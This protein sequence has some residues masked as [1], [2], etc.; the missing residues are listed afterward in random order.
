MMMMS[1]QGA[2][3]VNA[4]AAREGAGTVSAMIRS[5]MTKYYAP[6]TTRRPVAI[7]I[8]GGALLLMA[9]SGCAAMSPKTGVPFEDNFPDNS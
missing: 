6:T 7:A 2:G 1:I 9:M 5:A 4:V 8:V 3:T